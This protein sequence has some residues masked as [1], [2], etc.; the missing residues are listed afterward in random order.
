MPKPDLVLAGL[1]RKRSIKIIALAAAVPTSSNIGGEMNWLVKIGIDALETMF[2]AGVAGTI[3]V[4]ILSG[5]EDMR[6]IT[7]RAEDHD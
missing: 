7:G 3:V 4:L 5:I 6:T 1:N 2:A